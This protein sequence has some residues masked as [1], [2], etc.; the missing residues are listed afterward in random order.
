M[1]AMAEAAGVVLAVHANFPNC[2]RPLHI[3][4]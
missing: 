1:M 4:Q 3:P 2:K